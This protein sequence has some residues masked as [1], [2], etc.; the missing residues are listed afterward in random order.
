MQNKLLKLWKITLEKKSNG[1]RGEAFET[2]ANKK[3]ES[4]IQGVESEKF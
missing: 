1:M 2:H 4:R 3:I